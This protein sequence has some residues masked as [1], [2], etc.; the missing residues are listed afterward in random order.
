MRA[1][2]DIKTSSAV[3]FLSWM[4]SDSSS[5][6]RKTVSV[7][8]SMH[9]DLPLESCKADLVVGFSMDLDLPL[10]SCKT[11]LAAGPSVLLTSESL[12]TVFK[13]VMMSSIVKGGPISFSKSSQIKS[14][15]SGS[16]WDKTFISILRFGPYG[17][18]KPMRI[19]AESKWTTSNSRNLL[20]LFQLGRG[21]AAASGLLP[22]VSSLSS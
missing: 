6:L 3:G 15:G 17:L 11:V 22:F 18:Q 14:P 8:S 9:L 19:C 13:K 4:N 2:T 12:G 7:V 1:R 21:R 5:E 16:G 10:E 20:H